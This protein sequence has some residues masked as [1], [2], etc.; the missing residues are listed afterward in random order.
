MISY[1]YYLY[2]IPTGLKY[3]GARYANKVSPENDLWIHYFSSSK[4]VH[5][6]IEKYGKE[7][8]QYQIR[9]TFKTKE[10]CLDWEER[11]LRKINVIKRN[12]WLNSNIGG[13]NFYIPIVTKETREK[14]SLSQ[15]GKIIP[16]EQRNKISKKLINRKL[17]QE[18]KEKMSK[19]RKNKIFTEKHR[20]NLKNSR[21]HLL[22]AE[23]QS[24]QYEIIFKN[25]EKQ[26]I[27][28]LKKYCDENKI[29][30]SNASNVANGKRKTCSGLIFRKVEL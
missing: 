12:D 26:I 13:K 7:S 14:M 30:Y 29:D 25:G 19:S 17:P 2:H 23:K 1:T 20:N 4:K 9:K 24:K 27:T 28:N 5:E 10:E 22:Q 15:R 6:L 3:Y 16:I 18:T 8:F 21:G 11:F